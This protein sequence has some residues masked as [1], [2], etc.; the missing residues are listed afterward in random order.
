MSRHIV[1]TRGTIF[2]VVC[3]LEGRVPRQLTKQVLMC[4]VAQ[5]FRMCPYN[6]F[7]ETCLVI[8]I[9]RVS[10]HIQCQAID[11]SQL[12]QQGY[13][14]AFKTSSGRHHNI[15]PTLVDGRTELK[16]KVDLGQ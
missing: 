13:E 10:V 5:R 14:R 16:Q 6:D 2:T 9:P 7:S 8:V 1:K 4:V 11:A 12:Q 3:N 15:K